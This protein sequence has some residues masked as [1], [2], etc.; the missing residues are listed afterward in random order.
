MKIGNNTFSEDCFASIVGPEV[1]KSIFKSKRSKSSDFGKEVR[2]PF[3]VHAH[4]YDC[5][6]FVDGCKGWS[7][8]R[9]FACK[10]IKLYRRV[11]PG[12]K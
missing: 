7:A 9:E 3:D 1:K 11:E 12:V 2:R 10:K 8:Y 6:K 4:C 5:Q